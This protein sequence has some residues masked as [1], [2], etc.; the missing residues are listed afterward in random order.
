MRL[1][2][3]VSMGIGAASGLFCFFLMKRTQLGA[4]DFIWTIHMAQRWL[5]GQNPYSE[6]WQIYPFTAALFGLP[7]VHLAKE[8]AAAAFFGTSS[9]LLAFGLTRHGYHRLLI[10]LAYPYWVG[11]LY[12]QW[13]PLIAASAFFPLLLPATMAKPQV[14]IPVFISR[15]SWR[16]FWAC[17]VVAVASLI[18]LPRWP[19]LWL[20]EIG[21]YE[22]FFAILILPGP[23][24]LLALLRYR[25]RD[26]W[27][28]LINACMPQRYFFDTFILW[29]IPQSRR[30]ILI[31]VFF[32]WCSGLWRWFYPPHSI[33]Q[34]GRSIVLFTYLPMLAILLLRDNTET[35]SSVP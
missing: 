4:G 32:S 26:A 9:G 7:L 18:A 15:F 28:L 20:S 24:L 34:I 27:L 8:A 3:A 5:A 1:R 29:L 6:P 16:G 25:D 33:T 22:H 13:S 23:I 31:A 19:M 12:V 10:F 17:V 2:I 11:L 14:G 30:E 35:A 21:K